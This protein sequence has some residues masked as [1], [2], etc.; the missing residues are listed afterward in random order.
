MSNSGEYGVV[1]TYAMLDW[2]N[3]CG[4]VIKENFRPTQAG[5]EL[6]K[7]ISEYGVN[8][9]ID[10]VVCNHGSWTEINSEQEHKNG[11][12]FHETII[13][14]FG[15]AYDE[16]VDGKI[17]TTSHYKFSNQLDSARSFACK[18]LYIIR[19]ADGCVEVNYVSGSEFIPV[20]TINPFHSQVDY[21]EEMLWCE[22]EIAQKFGM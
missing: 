15:V 1:A 10:T 3:D 14:G 5:V 12:N 8:E 16:Y 7:L 21:Y 11:Y 20:N 13:D 22:E 19:Q 9:V 6:L 2:C 18:W 4:R 17:E